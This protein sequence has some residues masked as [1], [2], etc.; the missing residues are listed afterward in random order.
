M[1]FEFKWKVKFNL[2]NREL[3]SNFVMWVCMWMEGVMG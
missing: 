1:K 2:W 3:G